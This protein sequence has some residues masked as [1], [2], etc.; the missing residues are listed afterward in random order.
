MLVPVRL[1]GLVV[2]PALPTV[3]P[4]EPQAPVVP[5]AVVA[6]PVVLQL[7]AAP[8][9]VVP[10]GGVFQL[11]AVPLCMVQLFE[12]LL[13]A[14]V[15]P[16]VLQEFVG[17]CARPPCDPEDWARCDAVFSH[18]VSVTPARKTPANPSTGFLPIRFPFPAN[19]IFTP[20]MAVLATSRLRRAGPAWLGSG[21]LP[22]KA[23]GQ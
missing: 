21:G 2:I 1:A 7:F 18:P 16:W 19:S 10:L 4:W 14:T 13:P 12:V 8:L 17:R 20:P 15:V 3:L 5:L 11:L 6:V 9:L 22:R 23:A